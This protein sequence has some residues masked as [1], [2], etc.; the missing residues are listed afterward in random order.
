MDIIELIAQDESPKLDFKRE[1]YKEAD[2]K[3]ELIKDII[4]LTF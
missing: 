3:T 2:L 1:W 4:V